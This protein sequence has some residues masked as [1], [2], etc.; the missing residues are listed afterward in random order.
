MFQHPVFNETLHREVIVA[1]QD[2]LKKLYFLFSLYIEFC[3]KII[4]HFRRISICP[5]RDLKIPR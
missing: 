3:I 2:V 1:Q 4:L 5:P